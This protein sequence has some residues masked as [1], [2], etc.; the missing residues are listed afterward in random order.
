M[1]NFCKLLFSVLS[2]TVLLPSYAQNI[3]NRYRVESSAGPFLLIS[4]DS[5]AAA[6][7]DAG[8]ASSPDANAIFWNTAKLAFAET[9]AGA[10]IS[11]APWLRDLVGDM[12][13]LNGSY[14]KKIGKTQALTAGLTYFNQGQIEFTNQQGSSIGNFQS[15]E[16]VLTGGYTRRLSQSFSMGINLKYINSNLIGDLL[17]N[18]QASKPGTTVAGDI[19]FFYKKSLPTSKK[20]ES[21]TDYAFGLVIQNIG[22]KVNYGREFDYYLP[23]NLKFGTGITFRMDPKNTFNIL[24]DANKPLVPTPQLD[25]SIPQVSAMQAIFTS[26]NDAPE[27]Y[28]EL[29]EFRGS[30][31]AEYV[32]DNLLALRTGFFYENKFR[33]GRQYATAGIGLKLKEDYGLDLAYL[34]PVNSGNPL[35]NT[36]R[37]SLILHLNG[38]RK[39]AK[40]PSAPASIDTEGEVIIE[41]QGRR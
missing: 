1:K 24:L 15:R 20:K 22:G 5:R 21:G 37:M 19:S 29:A 38:S 11:Y 16:F 27:K 36:W 35:A 32:Y 3:T 41:S 6:M 25:G 2:T 23:A 10:S 28:G 8:V 13:L 30:F 17:V 40:S 26:F 33:G 12:G 4:P 18:N 34:V 14:Y 9:N 31:G 7:G 39:A